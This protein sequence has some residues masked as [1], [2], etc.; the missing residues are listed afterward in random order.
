MESPGKRQR[1]AVN[2]IFRVLQ[3]LVD[4]DFSLAKELLGRAKELDMAKV[5]CSLF[6][7]IERF[8][9]NEGDTEAMVELLVAS[10]STPYETAVVAIA[11]QRKGH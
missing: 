8:I 6:S 3:A 1:E 7:A 4:G 10:N 11:A 9:E 2:V 5:N